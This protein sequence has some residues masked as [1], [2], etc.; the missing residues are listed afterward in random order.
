MFFKQKQN[1]MHSF[2]L[3]DYI[4]SNTNI[5]KNVKDEYASKL[6]SPKLIAYNGKMATK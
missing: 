4:T 2:K 6:T 1:D 5:A 3:I